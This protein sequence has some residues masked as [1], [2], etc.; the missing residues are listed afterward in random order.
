MGVY[1][2]INAKDF[3]IEKDLPLF[4]L[5]VPDKKNLTYEQQYSEIIK[6]Q[7]ILLATIQ[8]YH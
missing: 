5:I 7:Q 8:M 6:N 2:I 4:I 3:P 1:K